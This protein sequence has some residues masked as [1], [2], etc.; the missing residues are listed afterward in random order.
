MKL[1]PR[2]PA[3]LAY[4]H[5]RHPLSLR[6]FRP[7]WPL[8]PS[9]PLQ[10]LLVLLPTL[11]TSSATA[12][13]PA[14]LHITQA[15]A[16]GTEV[17]AY[18]ALQDEAGAPVALEAPGQATAT[19]GAQ[20]AEVVAV[21]PFAATG[22]GVLYLFLVDQSRSLDPAQFERIRQALRIWVAALGEQ[23]RAALLTFGN[24]VRT[25]VAPT[26][27]RVALITA[28]DGLKP[29]DDRTAL[30]QALAQ[31][32]TLGRQ[33]APDLPS[34]RALVILSDG[35]DDAPG[36]MTTEE[37]EQQLAEGSVPIYAIGF[38]RGRDRAVR[39]AGLAALGRFARRS[40]G[41]FID[42]SAGD[43]A[44]AYA[45]LRERIRA[46]DKLE[47][48]CPTCTA[49]GN[50]YRL[51][52]AVTRNGRTLSDGM[53]VRLY[54]VTA[55]A[56]AAGL[57]GTPGTTPATQAPEGRAVAPGDEAVPADGATSPAV[58]V[59][60]GGNPASAAHAG[61][62]EHGPDQSG[63][64]PS[65]Q[66]REVSPQPGDSPQPGVAPLPE[67]TPQSQAT[68]NPE[69]TPQAGTTPQPGAPSQ[70]ETTSPPSE[71]TPLPAPAW[72]QRLLAQWPWWL[73]GTA[74]VVILLGVGL[75][76][77][78]RSGA[79]KEASAIP[80]SPRV[81]GPLESP[82][83][84]PSPNPPTSPTLAPTRRQEVPTGP[85]LNLAFMNGPRRG[86]MARVTLAPDAILGRHPASSLA[87]L[88][89]DE[90]SGRHARLFIQERRL[91]VEDLGS[92]NGT[93]L[94]GIRL[95][96]P[97]PVGEGDVV[98]CGQTELR[99]GAI[100]AS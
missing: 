40:G 31:G 28:I 67:A 7:L 41:R 46:V 79:A 66:A 10:L 85:T 47:L 57:P 55:G 89:D 96:A 92:T 1:P 25:L 29:T 91:L 56:E 3:L 5:L 34:R 19:L 13:E 58:T 14:S 43:P 63:Q 71:T 45:V 59:S 16:Q 42:A 44:E 36:G 38:S 15:L 64:Q 22:E 93:W 35:L 54:P 32:L 83:A 26:A 73:G 30:H 37:V 77:R 70:A 90:V 4:L 60:E 78:G 53:D 76:R 33:R 72:D 21:Q 51:Q 9:R 39:E 81:A 80:A 52:V 11:V 61:D 75:S 99:L 20:V 50:R 87:L 97:T 17:T 82:V 98:R 65:G 27:D 2:Y 18:V 88:G 95:R 6:R 86:Q 24:Q 49:D 12:M 68:P 69:A 8:R 62:A 94:N 100:G 74:L 84:M 23:D 48:R